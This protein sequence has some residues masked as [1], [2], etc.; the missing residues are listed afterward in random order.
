MTSSPVADVVMSA[1]APFSPLMLNLMPPVVLNFLAVVV[2]ESLPKDTLLSPNVLMESVA[3]FTA[4]SIC[5][6]LTA[7][8]SVVPLATFLISLLPALIPLVVTEIGVVPVPAGVTVIPVGAV[9]VML[10]AASVVVTPPLD[11]TVEL[12]A[13]SEIVEEPPVTVCVLPDP[14]VNVADVK[15]VKAFAILIFNVPVVVSPTTAILPDVRSVAVVL[16][17]PLMLSCSPC[18]RLITVASS[19]AKLCFASAK[20][21]AVLALDLVIASLIAVATFCVVATPFLPAVVPCVEPAAPTLP[22]VSSITSLPSS[23]LT[24]YV[25]TPAAVLSDTVARPVPVTVT[26]SCAAA[27]ATFLTAFSDTATS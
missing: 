12:P 26:A 4:S 24:V 14:S 18:L 25:L 1:F 10:P 27:L 5:F 8:S 21:C 11:T 9:V 16:A 17:P 6:L 3:A 15:P 2:P 7:A 20:A 13:A 22:V 19:P 23:T